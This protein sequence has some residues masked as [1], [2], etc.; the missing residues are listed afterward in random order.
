M[1]LSLRVFFLC[2]LVLVSYRRA[3]I[4]TVYLYA[5]APSDGKK[6]GGKE[7]HTHT[8]THTDVQIPAPTLA[9]TDKQNYHTHTYLL[10][11]RSRSFIK[12]QTSR[13]SDRV[14]EKV[15]YPVWE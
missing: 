2:F 12:P 11:L 5:G 1:Q 14:S 7:R 3:E 8:R 10:S 9:K 6:K 13:Q 4:R 15:E